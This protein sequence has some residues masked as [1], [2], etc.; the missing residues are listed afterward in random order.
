MDLYSWI[1][2]ICIGIQVIAIVSIM[3]S[4]IKIYKIMKEFNDKRD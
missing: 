1:Q 3:D 4:N 2:L